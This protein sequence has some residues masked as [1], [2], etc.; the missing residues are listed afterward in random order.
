MTAAFAS[1]FQI[2]PRFVKKANEHE[3]LPTDEVIRLAR[4]CRNGDMKARDRMAKTN[5]RLVVSMARSYLRKHNVEYD[6]LYQQ[7]VE[8]LMIAID[9]FDP[10]MGF[11]FTTYA[12]PWVRSKIE[13]YIMK[14]RMIHVPCK[15]MKMASKIYRTRRAMEGSL[16]HTVLDADIAD[17]LKITEKAVRD[18]TMVIQPH[19]SLDAAVSDEDESTTFLSLLADQSNAFDFVENDELKEVL[20]KAIH[21]CLDD[22]QRHIVTS[23]FGLGNSDEIDRADIARDINLSRERVRQLLKESIS[24]LKDKLYTM[25]LDSSN[26]L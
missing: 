21:E 23:F 16:G 2:E 25:G 13:E 18:L 11:A 1:T 3:I 9:K 20:N 12:M 7:G 14:E 17:E 15:T 19:R 22:R 5:L 24:I 26:A 10:E 6:V 8:G 4:L